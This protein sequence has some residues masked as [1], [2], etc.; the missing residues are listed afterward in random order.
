MTRSDGLA[1]ALERMPESPWRLFDLIGGGIAVTTPDGTL[2]F[3]NAALLDLTADCAPALPGSSIFGLL[4][5]GANGD[6]ERLHQAALATDDEVH[7]RVR[8]DR[9]RFSANAV[10][11][12]SQQ[13]DG[14]RVIWSFGEP[15]R[16][17]PAFE[18]A[19]WGT[20]IGL[21]DWDVP[22]DRL[23][24]IND[25]CEHSHFAAFAGA[26]HENSWCARIHPEDLPAYREALN[27][28]L[29]GRAPPTKRNTGFE[30]E[31]RHG[32]G[33]GTRQGHRA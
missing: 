20:E 12:R 33:L 29:E 4:I 15:E 30:M 23:I 14:R 21:W 11:R 27:G 26:G 25:W 16:N 28:H 9:G 24:W 10:L 31:T 2:E 7:A 5:G 32:S 1:H 22:T 8:S 13:P 3:C 19:L 17:E 18:V 6:L